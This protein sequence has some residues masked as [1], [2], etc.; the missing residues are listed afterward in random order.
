MLYNMPDKNTRLT[1][2]IN[3]KDINA[4]FY[5]VRHTEFSRVIRRK[6]ICA[7]RKQRPLLRSTVLGKLS[8][9]QRVCKNA[10]RHNLIVI[11]HQKHTVA[12]LIR[13]SLMKATGRRNITTKCYHKHRYQSIIS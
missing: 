4:Q 6:G 7:D 2:M 9:T 5:G 8:Y 12:I 1:F 13:H 11:E 10:T 3:H